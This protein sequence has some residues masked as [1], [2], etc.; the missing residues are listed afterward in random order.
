MK[1]LLV[2]FA[3]RESGDCW[4]YWIASS[5]LVVG[6]WLHVHVGKWELGYP[7]A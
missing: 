1:N 7:K 3:A 4:S 2:I 6:E 5:V